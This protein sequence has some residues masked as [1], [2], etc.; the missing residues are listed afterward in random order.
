MT[1]LEVEALATDTKA[2]NNRLRGIIEGLPKIGIPGFGPDEPFGGLSKATK[3][4]NV[5]VLGGY[6]GSILRSAD[7]QRMLWIPVK[8]GLGIRKVDLELPLDEDGE[9]EAANTIY[10][11]GMLT[12]IGPVDISRRLLRKLRDMQE[13]GF[14][15][16]HE[17]GYDWR[18]GG[19]ILSQQMIT[20]LEKL[21][22]KALVVAHSLGGL[23]TLGALNQRPDLFRGVLFAG[24]PFHGCPNIL[25]PFRYGDGVLLNR[26]VLNA[27]TNF[28]MRSSFMLLPTHKRCF[29]DIETGKELPV[30][31]FDAAAWR[32][33]GL[34]PMV[35]KDGGAS[36]VGEATDVNGI[37]ATGGLGG[38]LMG[39][40]TDEPSHSPEEAGSHP[41]SDSR[42]SELAYLGRTLASTLAFK[43]SLGYDSSVRYPPIALLRSNRTPTV[44]GCNVHG[45]AGIRAGDY[46][47][48]I[49]SPGDGVVTYA[50]SDLSTTHAGW[51]RHVVTDVENDRGH[52]GL[53]GDISGVS[54]CLEAILA[55]RPVTPEPVQEVPDIDAATHGDETGTASS[56]EK[57]AIAREIHYTHL[58]LFIL[59]N[60]KMSLTCTPFD[61]LNVTMPPH[62][63]PLLPRRLNRGE[64][65]LDEEAG[66][67]V[68]RL[69]NPLSRLVAPPKPVFDFLA[70]EKIRSASVSNQSGHE[71]SIGMPL[72]SK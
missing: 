14:C 35:A 61:D 10:A 46:S 70:G 71:T 57:L 12:H 20:F 18:L 56:L 16:V 38:P 30:D 67:G 28:S 17:F 6:R 11:D 27:Q 19:E 3:D 59:V 39:N 55:A 7:D 51:S 69:N 45:Y 1:S 25:G 50:S 36:D 15:Q 34:S 54:T 26:S 24:T 49:F 29:V 44:R 63:E 32:E 66:G 64:E 9:R 62:E 2:E 58:P 43:A 68:D 47:K 13:R 8:V 23:V 48:F 41:T 4:L 5:V 65:S 31:F 21:D 52:I 60:V 37:M 22:G 33:Y 42:A 40:G 72:A 53:L